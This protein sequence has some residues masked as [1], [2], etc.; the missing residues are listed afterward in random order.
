MNT[1]FYNGISGI[2]SHQF[3]LDIWANNISNMSTNG[4]IGKTPE[5]STQFATALTD[6]YF[7][8][9]SNDMGTG[10]K[11]SAASIDTHRQGSFLPTDRVFDLALDGKGWFGV[12]SRGS[13]VL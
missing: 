3:G 2:K 12:Q 9:T 7:D 10:S 4:F 8:A 6:N 5:F 13:Q 1:S 11:A